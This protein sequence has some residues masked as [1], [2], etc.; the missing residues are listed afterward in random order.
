MIN[1]QLA[2]CLSTSEK[3]LALELRRSKAQETWKG[4]EVSKVGWG[5]ESY[6]FAWASDP[7][8][9]VRFYLFQMK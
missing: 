6:L 9:L 8:G 5:L 7:L 3:A 1:W 2:G 4:K